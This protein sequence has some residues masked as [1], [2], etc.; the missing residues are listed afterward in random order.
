MIILAEDDPDHRLALTLALQLAGY[1]VR[2]AADGGEAL[3]LQ[4]ERPAA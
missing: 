4:R 1:P 2:Q 3:A